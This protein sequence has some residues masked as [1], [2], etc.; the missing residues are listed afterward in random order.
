M[1]VKLNLGFGPNPFKGWI[2]IDKSWNAYLYKIPLLKKLIIKLLLSLGWVTE[3]AIVHVV[4]YPPDLD[5]R[6]RDVRKGLKFDDMSVD[7]IYTSQMIEHLHRDDTIFVLQECYRVLKKGGI[8][9]V[10]VPDLKIYTREYMNAENSF[11]NNDNPAADKF[12]DALMLQG[13]GDNRPL[14]YKLMCKRHQWVYDFK[15]LAK[16]LY[17]CGF[18]KVKECKLGEG[19][20]PDVQE[21][22]QDY[23]LL[24]N[25]VSVFLEAV[26]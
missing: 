1:A 7:C 14:F 11:N 15:S 22:E 12:M 18:S 9:R 5:I 21:L 10:A 8:L 6:R 25:P 13:I 16:R 26:K 2:N 19:L 4:D 3:D 23:H 20:L 24:H 17:D